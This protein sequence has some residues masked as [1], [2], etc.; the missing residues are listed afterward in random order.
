[1]LLEADG[2]KRASMLNKVALATLG[3]K[4][5]QYESAGI[6]GLLS[7]SGYCVVPFDSKA[8]TYIIN[9]CTVT[10]KTDC[11]S[12][13]LIRRAHKRNPEAVI[14]VTG[15]YAQTAS[16]EVSQIPGVTVVAGNV[17]KKNIVGILQNIKN[18]S[19]NILV[20]DISQS[21]YFSELAVSMFPGHTRAFLKIQDGCDAFCTY[22]I[23]PYAR[24]PSRSMP[25]DK[26]L[27]QMSVLGHAGF[28]EVVLTG[29]HLGAYGQDIIPPSG[30]LEL[31][32]KMEENKFVERIRL[33]SL[34]PKEVSDDMISLINH[35]K[36]ICPHLH[37]PLQSGDD[38]ILSAMGRNYDTYFFKTL[39]EKIFGR[40]RD[41]AVGIDVMVGFPGEREKEFDHTIQMIE[42]FPIAYLHVFPFS[43]RPGT[44]ASKLP[45]P[46]AEEDKKRR[47]EILRAIGKKKRESF[48]Q[49]FKNKP[50]AVL[51]EGKKDRE[52]GFMKGF[53]ANY[54]PVM[55]TNGSLSLINRIV[56]ITPDHGKNGTLFGKVC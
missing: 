20:N 40:I 16:Q 22:C 47:G 50:L 34:E 51:I 9:T 3:C 30:L 28:R 24:G 32:T 43:K 31:L 54:I 44:P 5:N 27:K 10:H 48:A 11:Q 7:S 19:Q 6:T 53:S 21:K 1:M 17:E 29:I 13:Q 8:D 56:S 49:R 25:F 41:V 12:R 2:L 42:E 18:S 46:V 39:L 33:S 37:I 14:I 26:V 4:V 36:M 15:C 35:S 55:V 38:K 45:D 52:T 23:V